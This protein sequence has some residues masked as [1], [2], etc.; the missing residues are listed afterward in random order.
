MFGYAMNASLTSPPL[1]KRSEVKPSGGGLFSD[2]ETDGAIDQSDHSKEP[3]DL[4]LGEDLFGSTPTAT[5]PTQTKY[6][7]SVCVC[8]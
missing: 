1:T 6:V 3:T 2:E 4:F 8:V 5:P 7:S